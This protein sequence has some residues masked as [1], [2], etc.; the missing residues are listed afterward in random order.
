MR[1]TIVFISALAVLAAASL[2]LLR[3][4][5]IASRQHGPCHTST[6]LSSVTGTVGV[7]SEPL[8]VDP[9][10]AIDETKANGE[11]KN[12]AVSRPDSVGSF[13][14]GPFE[15]VT[16]NEAATIDMKMLADAAVRTRKRGAGMPAE[17]A[18]VPIPNDHDKLAPLVTTPLDIRGTTTPE[19]GKRA[20]SN[21]SFPLDGYEDAGTTSSPSLPPSES[22]EDPDSHS[23]PKTSTTSG[24]SKKKGKKPGS[25]RK[26]SD[27]LLSPIAH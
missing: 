21:E 19:A 23:L 10:S 26:A 4:S 20:G 2:K 24:K 5:N 9:K 27:F 13:L 18:P 14:A 22:V 8:V 1:D 25:R 15:S 12:P 11:C 3:A 7:F 16:G 6:G 17:L